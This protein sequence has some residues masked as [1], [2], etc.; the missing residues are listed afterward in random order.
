MPN[1]PTPPP[2]AYHEPMPLLEAQNLIKSYTGR[3]VVDKVSFHVDGGEI[4]GLLGRNGAG[5][6][7]SFRMVIGMI[8]PEGGS[9]QFNGVDVTREPMFR[10]AR[11]G[12]GYLSQ[13]PSVFQRMTVRDNLMAILETRNLSRA[14]QNERCDA[15]MAQFGLEHKA[16]ETARTCSGGERRRLE[17]A[18]AMVTEPTMLLLDEPFAAVDPH[19]VEELQHE[20]AKLRDE[21]ISILVT[22]H[23]VQQTLR[24]CD[25]AYIIHHGKNLREGDPKSIINDE[26]VREAYL[27]STFRGDEFD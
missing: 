27:A 21:G 11:L 20:V 26:A 12:M 18:R 14:Q 23:N 25:R 17:I 9:V 5:K 3:R 1:Q 10:H 13:E 24:I 4:V 16:K 8:T 2:L 22:D 7:T 19:T 6:T 15:L